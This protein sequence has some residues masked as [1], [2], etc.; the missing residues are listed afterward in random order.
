MGPHESVDVDINL[1]GGF[2]VAVNSRPV[3][4][5]A[6]RRRSAA[7]L[8]K[9]LALQPGRSLLRDRV[10]DQLWPELS[11]AQASPRL[12]KAAHY[13]R[14]ALGIPDAL[15]LADDLVSLLPGHHVDVDVARFDAAAAQAENAQRRLRGL[16]DSE[17]TGP[18]AEA[19]RLAEEALAQYAGDLLP[20]DL[21]EPWVDQ[22]REPRRLLRLRLLR[23]A[24][25][26]E[27]LVE[28][29]PTD[30]E[31]HLRV[32]HM[33]AQRGDRP[34]A[35]RSLDRLERTARDEL[36]V[37]VSPAA[38]RLREA[39]LAHP[40]EEPS[41]DPVVPPRGATPV[42][43]LAGR[44]VGR[45]SEIGQALDLL[46]RSRILTL[47]GPGG[48]GK[49][50]LAFEVAH[51]RSA[52]RA[53]DACFVDLTK[54]DTEA[55]V[56]ALVATELGL[57]H[58]RA[59][60]AEQALQEALRGRDLVLL[61]DNFEHVIDAAGLVTRM[62]GWSAGVEI[63]STSRSRL[64]V[65]DEQVL[66]VLPFAVPE[67]GVTDGGAR[68]SDAVV[69]FDQVACAIDPGFD[70]EAHLEDVTDICR[71]VDGLPLA[72][73]LAAG[74][75]RTLPPALLR[76]RLAARLGSPE[77]ATRDAPSR[78]R[79][80]P[81]TI[82]WSLQLLAESEVRL[83]RRLGVFA[84]PA[85]LDA[86]EA[87]CAAPE[88][89]VLAALARLVD[90]SLVQRTGDAAD[91]R[92]RMLEL[93]RQQSR[94]L[95]AASPDDG[96]IRR[97]HAE[98]VAARLEEIEQQRWTTLTGVWIGMISAMLA[99]VRAAH[100][101]AEQ[102][103]DV[104]LAARISAALGTFWHREGHHV[105]ARQWVEASLVHLDELDGD[106]A[107][108]L[109]VAA[110]LLTWTQDPPRARDYWDQATSRFRSLGNDRYLSYALGLAAGTYIGDEES[111]ELALRLSEEAISLGRTV[112]D[113][114]LIAQSLNVM[115]ELAR[116][117]GDDDLALQC[118]LEGRDLAAAA[119][120]R[121]HESVF[122]ANL[123]YLAEHRGE[124]EEARSLARQALRLSWSLGLRM[125]SAWTVSGIAGPEL[126]L[127]HPRVASRLVGA[128]DQA[129]A[130]L[131]VG[132]H[133]GDQQ[134]QERVVEGLR[135]ALG[136][137]AYEVLVA[138]GARLTL[139]EAVALALAGEDESSGSPVPLVAED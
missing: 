5:S 3:P 121:A 54:A 22:E 107:G 31:A 120:D 117:H 119:D 135:A 50:T 95:L 113:R 94:Q 16:P 55:N 62:A 77:G 9:L 88:D 52:A 80:I 12:H 58:A 43:V 30:E 133:L 102:E 123:A 116:D 34:A 47:L 24:E 61:L 20:G 27:D 85:T 90:Q 101:W 29:D 108:R 115:G 104:V 32:A 51:R 56:A 99:E 100:A 136:D 42:P 4:E 53:V 106:V 74:H 109:L 26:W 2:S 93:I 14:A 59:S 6:W 38:A 89:D 46:G 64:Q 39:V 139:A 84:A 132:R 103:G 65:T 41:T 23:Q 73:K 60:D 45:D 114:P 91:T 33:L 70:L 137:A 18:R 124:Y 25:R 75:V 134:E 15:V 78:Q 131:G 37:H 112:G 130:T 72:I 125:V 76:T 83:F 126:G 44:L 48:V 13:A 127:G 7:A 110:A 28:A 11:V 81:A 138:E 122:L 36:G 57:H 8:V 97:R 111:Y 92:F 96:V 21:Y 17:S 10:V 86:V 35:L 118:Y 79:T 67:A 98:Y 1:L 129:L 128:G 105:E 19:R 68:A 71:T 69:L 87:V 49:T 40:V 66:D 82:D 63:V